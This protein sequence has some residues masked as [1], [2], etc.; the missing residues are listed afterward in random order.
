MARNEYID[1]KGISLKDTV[2]KLYILLKNKIY[3]VILATIFSLFVTAIAL[4]GP[5]LIGKMTDILVKGINITENGIQF[6]IDYNLLFQK[7]MLI[8]AIYIISFLLSSMQSSIMAFINSSL[9]EEI[10][11]NVNNKINSLPIS[12]LDANKDGNI[13]SIM[14]NDITTLC[15]AFSNILNFIIPSILTILGTII[16]M[17]AIS[18]KLMLIVLVFIPIMFISMILIIV[19][20]QKYFKEQ[21]EKLSSLNSHI[22]EMYANH[23][24]I[25]AYNGQK[26]SIN[27]F[28]KINKSLFKSAVLSQFFSGI[29]WPIISVVNNICYSIISLIGSILLNAGSFTIGN[30]QSF[31]QY[32]NQFQGPLGNISQASTFIQQIKATSDRI[33]KFL[34]QEEMEDESKLSKLNFEN[35][36]GNVEFKNVDFSYNKDKK[37]LDNLNFSVKEGEKVAI[38]GH[39]GSGK[40]TIINLLMKFYNINSGDIL[41]DGI[42]IKDIKREDI[43]DLFTMVLQDTW[44]FEDT[45]LENI[46]FGSNKKDISFEEVKKAAIEANANH[47][48]KTLPDG[49][50]TRLN[51]DVTNIS[52]GQK[53]LL[54]IA[55]AFLKNS[56]ILILDEATSSI[57]SRT[58]LLVQNSME[59]LMKNKTTFIIAH[60]LSTIRNCDKII[61]LD[62]GKIIEMGSHDELMKLNGNYASLYN[63]QF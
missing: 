62:K 27:E 49:Y 13:I 56:K 48:I 63:S 17:G 42:S 44:L 26:L 40:T 37:I 16:F 4:Q 30:F 12:Y 22:E 21:Q 53:Q 46:K 35:I 33:F 3:L 39:T 60:R 38:V 51:E 50:N 59:N 61:L 7:L 5:Y 2:K 9:T 36:K 10:R 43:A 6:N 24:V 1:T 11:T 47:F 34:T 32:L 57:D 14:N 28:D 31:I 41:I 15:D 20:S 25:Q 52:V 55:R 54:T 58:E 18:I 23:D 8:L 29:I 19:N 45:I